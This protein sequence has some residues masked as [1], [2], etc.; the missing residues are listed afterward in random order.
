[1]RDMYILKLEKAYASDVL[2]NPDCLKPAMC[3]YFKT[4]EMAG[5]DYERFLGQARAQGLIG[6]PTFRIGRR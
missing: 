1:M 3:G 2:T 5:D 4:P 6:V